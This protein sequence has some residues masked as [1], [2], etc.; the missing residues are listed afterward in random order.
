MSIAIEQKDPNGINNFTLDWS[1][2]LTALGGLTILNSPAPVWTVPAGL[3]QV[4]AGNTAS[5]TTIR[6]SGG[7]DGAD[8]ELLCHVY[9]SDGQEEEQSLIIQVRHVEAGSSQDATDRSNALALLLRWIEKDVVPPL[10]Q[11]KIEAILESHKVASTWK[12]NTFYAMG[13]KLLPP[14]RNGWW[15][16]VLQPGTS[17]SSNRPYNQWPIRYGSQFG[18]GSSDPQLI[19]EVAGE[20]EIFRAEPSN[21]Q[22]I[23]CYDVRGAARECVQQRLQL[24]V[25][26]VDEGEIS[27]DQLTKHL[28]GLLK[29]FYPIRF[30]VKVMR[31]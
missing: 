26:Y 10:D 24:G 31:A 3:T 17:Q 1:A 20:D 21:P 23:N 2:H 5:T 19:L 9:L 6:L 14:V 7:T 12:A 16:E 4:T 22:S 28:E 15:Y 13:Q 29:R 25:Q 11:D 18:D 8:Y 30:P 27:F